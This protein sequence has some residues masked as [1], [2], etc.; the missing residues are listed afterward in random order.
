MKLNLLTDESGRIVAAHLSTPT[1][2]LPPPSR[3]SSTLIKPSKGQSLHEVEVPAELEQHVL[4]NTLS[5]E[6][7]KWKVERHGKAAK[8]VKI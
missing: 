8:L 1:L 3:P 5:K 6:F 7:S 2:P 4:R